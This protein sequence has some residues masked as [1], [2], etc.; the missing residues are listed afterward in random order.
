M[1]RRGF[2]TSSQTL[3][4]ASAY[5]CFFM[6][7]TMSR[8]TFIN[9]NVVYHDNSKE[10]NIDARGNNL[11]A[12]LRAC[13]A[14]DIQAED[15]T[16]QEQQASLFRFIHPSVTE[17]A[18]RMKVHREV[19]NLVSNFPMVDICKHLQQMKKD[20]R[21][22]LNVKPEVMFAEL[23]RMGMPDEQTEGFSYKNFM[24]YFNIN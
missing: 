14:Q 22:Y 8:P 2:T 19:S 15:V 4:V 18:D 21:V 3:L 20:K 6:E 24:H 9:S 16:Q 13:E 10:Y 7:T 12:V 17:D 5:L 23:H 11:D 1:D